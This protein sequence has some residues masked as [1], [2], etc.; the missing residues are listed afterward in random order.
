LPDQA[1]LRRPARRRFARGLQTHPA[2]FSLRRSSLMM[3][4]KRIGTWFAAGAVL[5]LMCG[6][7]AAGDGKNAKAKTGP[8]NIEDEFRALKRRG[9]KVEDERAQLEN[10]NKVQDTDQRALERRHKDEIARLE[11]FFKEAI[12]QANARIDR[13]AQV[14]PPVR[15]VLMWWGETIPEGWEPC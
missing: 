8:P 13:V 7:L 5:L 6:A 14:S 10:K 9:T 4:S 12:T 3:S 2:L 11:A 1:P 15:S